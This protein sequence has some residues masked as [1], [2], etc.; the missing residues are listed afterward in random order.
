MTTF[1]FREKEYDDVLIGLPKLVDFLK[2]V[3]IEFWSFKNISLRYINP[4]GISCI[5]FE[6]LTR[7]LA[8]GLIVSDLD[9]HIFLE[10]SDFQIMDG[11]IF[12]Y[13]D[14]NFNKSEIMIE[15]VDC[16]QWEISTESSLL[17]SKLEKQGFRR[18]KKGIIIS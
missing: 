2:S 3:E 17:V 15:C 14:S 5:D 8:L 10:N 13:S 6:K 12:G 11:V 1:S 7:N 16:T 18:V 4:F 9:F